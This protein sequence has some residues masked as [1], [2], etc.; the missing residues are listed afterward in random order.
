M[1]TNVTLLY[2]LL[3]VPLSGFIAWLGDRIGHKTGKRRHTLFGLRPRH[4]AMLFTVGTGMCISMVSFALM[5]CLSKAF[6][7]IVSQ[8]V[9]LVETNIELRDS[10]KNLALGN[11]TLQHQAAT[12]KVDADTANRRREAAIVEEKKATAQR[13]LAVRQE[14]QAEGQVTASRTELA[15][16]ITRLQTAQSDLGAV[17]VSLATAKTSLADKTR[18]LVLAER[19]VGQAELRV[20]AASARAVDAVG[21][22]H[23]AEAA[24]RV[25]VADLANQK[26]QQEK[27]LASLEKQLTDENTL[28]VAQKQQTE[29]GR[30]D[31]ADLNKQLTDGRKELEDGRQ[32][33]AQVQLNTTAL[34]EHQI[35][36]QVG[37]EVDR[38]A[39]KPGY[40]VWRIEAILD[41][42]LTTAARKAEARGARKS[43]DAYR[44]VVILPKVVTED[45][46]AKP[47]G[48]GGTHR[49][50]EDETIRQAAASIRK[51]NADVVVLVSATANAVAGEPVAVDLKLYKNPIV[52]TADAPI[53]DAH[54]DGNGSP[55]QIADALYAFLLHAGIIP[56]SHGGDETDSAATL[57]NLSGDDWLHIMDRIRL[58]GASARVVVT[59][60]H[61]L[62]AGDSPALHFDVKGVPSAA[63]RTP[64]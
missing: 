63:F 48:A 15:A 26:I 40:N 32:K 51:A 23:T 25:A 9:R 16:A 64:F 38:I 14:K 60:A 54:I 58:A 13:D 39:I 36:Y 7:V 11:V 35:T 19:K 10:N 61:D 56:P 57:V 42:F 31:L 30:R 17:R 21:K 2:F 4:T 49:A 34:R 37:E 18:H 27:E 6:R 20:S 33:L 43:G 55:Q 46:P 59:A 22:A 29:Q 8:G 53:G 5:C 44:A 50:D 1:F 52:F 24:V 28:F 47:I 62:R 45:T 12:R 41:S 3:L